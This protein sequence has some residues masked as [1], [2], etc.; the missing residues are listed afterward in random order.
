MP[1]IRVALIGVGNCASAL[2]QGVFLYKN[3]DNREEAVGL[4]NLYLGGYHPRDL[5]FVCAFD[6]EARKVGK[7]LSEAILAPPNSALKIADV[8]EMGVE[9]LKGPVLDGV[10]ENARSKMQISSSLDVNVAKALRDSGA[11]VVVDLLP[12]GALKASGWYAEQALNA[13]CA[14]INATPALIASDSVWGQRFQGAGLPLAGDDLMSQ[15]GSTILHKELLRSLV[16]RGVRIQETYQLDVGGGPESLDTLERTRIR[17][18]MVKTK[19]AEVVLP[20]RAEVVAGSMD[21]VDFL[22]NS[23]DSYFWI[24]GLYFGK[25]PFELDIRLTTVDA[26]N[27]GAILLDAIRAVKIALDRKVAGPL[28]SVSAYAFKHPPK[29]LDPDVVERLFREFVLGRRER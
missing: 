18:R 7:D 26:P 27:A 13:G 1:K 21:Y 29:M 28:L 3:L 22:R 23:R 17:K 20:H 19:S 16:N 12:G 4:K 5:D 24:R 10:S 9:V 14:F 11:E 15:I 6:I 2:I 8:S 25:V